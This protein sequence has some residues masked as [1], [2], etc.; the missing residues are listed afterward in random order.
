MKKKI[1]LKEKP[2]KVILVKV[3]RAGDTFFKNKHGFVKGDKI[4]VM[5]LGSKFKE[6]VLFEVGFA[7]ENR[8]QASPVENKKNLPNLDSRDL[9]VIRFNRGKKLGKDTAK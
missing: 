2:T 9:Q 1:S 6:S 8:F 7:S 5:N 4:I 3:K